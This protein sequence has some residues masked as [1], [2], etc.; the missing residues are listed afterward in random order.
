ML[1]TKDKEKKR[2]SVKQPEEQTNKT[3]KKTKKTK[4]ILHQRTTIKIITNF[5]SEKFKIV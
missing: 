4:N 1:K 2:E 3:N 5:L